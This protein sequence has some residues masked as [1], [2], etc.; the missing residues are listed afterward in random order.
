VEPDS[1][2]YG[3]GR[4]LTAVPDCRT[5]CVYLRGEGQESWSTIPERCATFD[6]RFEVVA[7]HSSETGLRRAR[8]LSRAIIDKLAEMEERHFARTDRTAVGASDGS[9]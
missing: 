9:A 6:V 3:V 7:P 4:L 1:V 8:D 2:T 5:I